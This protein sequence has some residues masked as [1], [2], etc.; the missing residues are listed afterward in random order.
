MNM[1]RER[2]DAVLEALSDSTSHLLITC[3]VSPDG[4]AVG[5]AIAMA[6]YCDVIARPYTLVND[7]P[8]P[9]RYDFLPGVDQFRRTADVKERFSRVVALDCAD[10]RRLG[11]V[12]TLLADGYTLINIDHHETNDG[13]GAVAL[14]EPEASATCLVLYRLFRSADI[15]IGRPLAL[16]LYTGIVFDTGGFRYNNTTPEI[17]QVAADLL[18]RGIEPFMVADR[19][20]EAMTRE[21]AELVRLGLSTL[22]VDPT[23]RVAHLIV[24]YDMFRASGAEE[25]DADVLL[26]YTRSLSGVEVGILFRERPDGSVKASLRSRERVDVAAIALQFSGGGHVRASGCNIDG[27]A[28]A[29]VEKVLKVVED[30][31]RTAFATA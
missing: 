3:H 23:G 20:L 12:A 4:D 21:Q 1:D 18:T 25:S 9:G 6:L 11:E 16:A 29:A 19:V 14:V 15:P 26:P 2:Y 31:V 30:A 10:Y 13:Y 5:A 8:I 22:S 28:A 17:H 27:P 24:T 7:D